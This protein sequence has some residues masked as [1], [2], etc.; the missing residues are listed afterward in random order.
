MLYGKT[1]I[2]INLIWYNDFFSETAGGGGK[3]GVF[4]GG[5]AGSSAS[6]NYFAS[7]EGAICEGP[8]AQ[9][10]PTIWN[11]KSITTIAQAG[12]A[13]FLGTDSQVAWSHVA[14]SHP[15]Q[16]LGYRRTAYV[17]GNLSLG[18]SPELPNYTFEVTSTIANGSAGVVDANP[19]DVIADY[20]SNAIYGVPGWDS[21]FN[22]DWGAASGYW[23][24]TSLMV[25]VALTDQTTANQWL[26]DLIESLN[27]WATFSEGVLKIVPLGDKTIV[28]GAVANASF[29][30]AVP[31]TPYDPAAPAAV[32]YSI[33]A[34]TGANFVADAGV[35]YTGSGVTLTKVST[36]PGT[37]QYAV[38]LNGLYA[39]AA[40]DVGVSVTISYTAAA[41]GSYNPPEAPLYSW[42]DTD[43]LPNQG[44]SG[45]ST[46]SDPVAAQRTAPR[47]IN[48]V[49]KV[50]YLDRSGDYNPASLKASDD[51][52]I[53]LY[54]ERSS[55][56]TR[57]WDWFQFASAA[58]LAASLALGREKIANG[59]T[60]TV[61]PRYI[62]LDVGDIVSITDMLA[63]LDAQWCRINEIQENQDRSLTFTLQEYLQGTGA[64]P[65]Y[66]TGAVAGS[67]PNYNVD[68]GPMNAPI[69][70]E[71]T[72][73]LAGGLEIW[74]AASAPDQYYGGYDAYVSYD[75]TTYSF[76]GRQL[77]NARMGALSAPLPGLPVNPTG[78][79]TI[80]TTSTLSVD[81]TESVA[82][83]AS[84]T[85]T[86]A[87]ALNTACYVDGEIVA[88]E[89]ATLTAANKYDL[90]YLV[91]GAFGSE[92]SIS[93]HPLGSA[94]A[95]LDGNIM[96]I[97]FDQS[98]IGATV[99]I[100]LVPFNLWQGGPATVADVA[101]V[102]YVIK[103]TALTSSLPIV[104]NVVTQ[105]TDLF[106]Y[107]YWD[108]VND[109]RT[110]VRYKIY[111]G[112]TF[113]GAQQVGDNAHA[114]F[115]AF[116]LGTYWIVAYCQP[117]AGLYV[118]SETPASVTISGNLLTQNIVDSSDQ[119]AEG[120]PGIFSNGVG[121]S[122]ANIAL[123]GAGDILSD[124]DFLNT[125]DVLNYGGIIL[126]GTYEIAPS[127]VV[128]VGYTANCYVN[129]TWLATGVPVG[130]DVLTIADFLAQ[131]DILGSAS[132][133]YIN[134]RV[135]I[136]TATGPLAWSAWADFVP[137]V[138]RA[139]W[140]KLRLLIET[141]DPN[142]IPTVIAFSYAVSIPARVDHY[143]NLTVPGTGLTV[144][145][146][147][148]DAS[149]AFPFNGGPLVGGVANQ[150][151]PMTN[152][153]W[154]NNPGV[155][156]HV[157]SL[158]LSAVTFHFTDGSGNP[159]DVDNVNLI[160]E[161]Y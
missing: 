150:T 139:Q 5:G 127:D 62:L 84:V 34:G 145:F 2:T 128:D 97:P 156:P 154:S 29:A 31:N 93:V 19:K 6:T 111:K 135:Q 112:S 65:L 10:G 140:I 69:I 95:R 146:E 144:T 94:F 54:G 70:F 81:L 46:S 132:T 114:P 47:K 74:V 60:V 134:V 57:T 108:D 72:D 71:P 88:Y 99:E 143:P 80:D 138:Y 68:P 105:F 55:K 109:F 100:K 115:I 21:S 53:R 3:G 15:T 11:S 39:F 61:R 43:F 152:F 122:G 159:V 30:E 78:P 51:S 64:A 24:A 158:S 92:D 1:R 49:V 121:K 151:L 58:Q 25:S 50:D 16:A 9:I 8:V 35:K 28:A 41:V 67:R 90:T 130:Q 141:V 131:P 124:A 129:A 91:R 76:V 153:S 7:I 101:P 142:T 48:N 106:Q 82:N 42:T 14:S 18:G 13:T 63:G 120:W 4:G 32:P 38:S 75:G 118:Y 161:G 126:S 73:E 123:G 136:A 149:A 44:D 27:C 155:T 66:G 40:G 133:Q 52:L 87:L 117:V 33:Q 102:T 17:A 59:Y 157:D 103:G 110:G 45:G 56:G 36:T 160:A 26:G 37:G 116:G 107:I 98:R 148:D 20:L 147:P 125:A 113:A 79:P 85:Q 96:R 77:G 89:T 22:G 86:D 119:Q 23:L 12:F 137:G 104:Q 83:L